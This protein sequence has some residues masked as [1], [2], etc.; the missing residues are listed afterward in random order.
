LDRFC[1]RIEADAQFRGMM[2]GLLTISEPAVFNAPLFNLPVTRAQYA[3]F[4][5]AEIDDER[6]LSTALKY[7]CFLSQL[8]NSVTTFSDTFSTTYPDKRLPGAT[9]RLCN[10]FTGFWTDQGRRNGMGEVLIA[11]RDG[12]EIADMSAVLNS[13]IRDVDQVLRAAERRRH[14][15]KRWRRKPE[16]RTFYRKLRTRLT[17]LNEEMTDSPLRVVRHSASMTA[18]SASVAVPAGGLGA[19][20]ALGAEVAVAVFPRRSTGAAALTPTS[21]P[22]PAGA[23]IPPG[24]GVGEGVT[25]TASSVSSVR[26]KVAE[27]V[28]GSPGDAGQ[29][30]HPWRVSATAELRPPRRGGVPAA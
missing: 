26:R 23:F 25:A 20:A 17:R 24:A 18:V 4:L 10:L 29:P 6:T 13:M 22:S 14:F 1:R 7:F 11:Q 8:Y 21:R 3:L 5:I 19:S 12:K 15:I 27:V 16:T 2:T 28:P 30:P 9:Q